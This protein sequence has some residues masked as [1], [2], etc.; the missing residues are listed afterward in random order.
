M[1]LYIKTILQSNGLQ[2]EDKQIFKL[3]LLLKKSCIIE[4]FILYKV[5]KTLSYVTDKKII[6]KL[7]SILF[8]ITYVYN[9]Q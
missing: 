5:D 3:I 1:L 7:S 2:Q 4:S 8:N 6:Y 9:V